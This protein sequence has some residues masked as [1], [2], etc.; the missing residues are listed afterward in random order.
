MLAATH[1]WPKAWFRRL[2][3]HRLLAASAVS[4]LTLLWACRH[5]S[6][7]RRRVTEKDQPR[8]STHRLVTEKDR[9]RCHEDTRIQHRAYT[10]AETGESIPYALCVPPSYD[11]KTAAPLLLVLHGLYHT[12]DSLLTGELLDAAE[13]QNMVVVAP[14]GYTQDGWYGAPDL[15]H[16]GAASVKTRRSEL[17]VMRVVRLVRKEL[18]V[19]AQRV[20]CFGF[21]MGGAGSL[22]LA[23]R[24]PNLFAALGLAAP[25]VGVPGDL[26]IFATR[27]KLKVLANVPTMV[28]QGALDGPVPVEQTRQLVED[29]RKACMKV[30]YLELPRFGHHPPQPAMLRELVKF[31]AAATNDTPERQAFRVQCSMT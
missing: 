30:K 9:A 6:R 29:M 4:S 5:R 3:F 26:P 17:D 20:Y 24:N 27:E 2:W 1:A 28:V 22:N 10:F 19:D 7:A 15:L 14:L 11:P 18:K 8:V 21:S 31:L 16:G 12:Y 25:A 23:L 13:E